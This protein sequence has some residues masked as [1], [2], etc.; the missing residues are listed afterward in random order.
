[1]SAA[2]LNVMRQIGFQLLLD[3]GDAGPKWQKVFPLGE[4]RHRDDFGSITFTRGFLEGMLRNYVAEGKPRRQ[5]DYFHRGTSDDAKISNADKVA[6]GW[7]TD[8][9]VRDDGLYVLTEWTPRAR[10]AI[11]AKELQYPSPTFTE[12]ATD[13]K[14]GK[15]CGPKLFAVALLNDPFLTDLPAVQASATP[16]AVPKGTPMTT[17]NLSAIVHAAKL[18]E[19]STTAENIEAALTAKLA[20]LEASK[21]E[22]VQLKAKVEAKENAAGDIVRKLTEQV[23]TLST[24]LDAQEKAAAVAA[25]SALTVK[26]ESEGRILATEKPMVAEI[27]AAVGLEKATSMCSG[28]PVKVDLKERGSGKPGPVDGM[29]PEEAHKQLMLKAD[30]IVKAG[31]DRV[32]SYATA[33]SQNPE[34]AKAATKLTA[35]VQN[36]RSG[37][38]A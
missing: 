2:P 28:W 21:A 24:K 9:Q 23:S 32:T 29:A 1:M 11:D 10:A 35:K 33:M 31:G 6:S 26:L 25:V 19:K 17:V 3:A 5:W 38:A 30:E 4:T 27:V 37:A 12:N 7:F 14:T 8:M 13:P 15:P 36:E 22:V 18:D 34:L 16:P 20:E